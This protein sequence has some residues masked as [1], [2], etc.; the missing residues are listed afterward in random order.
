MEDISKPAAAVAEVMQDYAYLKHVFVRKLYEVAV[1]FRLP[2]AEIMALQNMVGKMF[3][4]L[5]YSTRDS[6]ESRRTNVVATMAR[7]RLLLT[8][9]NARNDRL[10]RRGPEMDE[11]ET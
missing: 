10:Q 5:E 4:L 6:I 8:Q 11:V 3:G 7:Q 1:R 2:K 9:A